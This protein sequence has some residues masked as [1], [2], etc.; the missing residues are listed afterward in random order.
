MCGFSKGKGPLP[1]FFVHNVVLCVDF[2]LLSHTQLHFLLIFTY[3][4]GYREKAMMKPMNN[5]KSL[6]FERFIVYNNR[7]EI[8]LKVG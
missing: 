4:L 3:N 2:L 7:C 5:E 8:L 1:A 6:A